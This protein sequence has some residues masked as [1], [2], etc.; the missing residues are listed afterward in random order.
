MSVPGQPPD[1]FH[2]Y[3]VHSVDE[4]DELMPGGT[5]QT[6][7]TITYEG[8]SGSVHTVKVPK[9]ALTAANVDRLIQE[10]LLH[11]EA[12]HGLGGTPHPENR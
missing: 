9:S 7:A 5:F 11:V 4:H 3:T 2:Q 1:Q 6:I 8:P 10:D 12:I